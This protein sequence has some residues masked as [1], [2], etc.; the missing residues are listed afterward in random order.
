MIFVNTRQ[1][2]ETLFELLQKVTTSPIDCIHGDKPQAE[3]SAA[4]NQFKRGQLRLLIAT[5]VAA[6][7]LD[8]ADIHCGRRGLSS[9]SQWSISMCRTASTSTFIALDALVAARLPSVSP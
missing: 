9:P 8:V 1:A 3:R 4:M 7:G 5:D 2:A 6:R